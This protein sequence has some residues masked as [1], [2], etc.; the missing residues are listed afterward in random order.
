MKV[1]CDL[2][3]YQDVQFRNESS[4]IDW[5]VEL[6]FSGRVCVWSPPGFPVL[7]LRNALDSSHEV[8]RRTWLALYCALGA[9]R[10]DLL[11]LGGPNSKE[12]RTMM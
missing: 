11:S 5:G 7:F 2:E 1:N 3:I 8:M 10:V 12:Q 6:V 4:E 9:R